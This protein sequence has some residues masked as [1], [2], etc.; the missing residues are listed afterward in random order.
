[1][2]Y[3]YIPAETKVEIVLRL[4]Q[5]ERPTSLE[6]EFHIPRKTLYTWKRQAEDALYQL[7]RFN[8][9]GPKKTTPYM[10]HNCE[11]LSQK[12]FTE[13]RECPQCA[14]AQLAKNGS[15]SLK[16]GVVKQRLLC[17]SCYFQIS[18]EKKTM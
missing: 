17:K 4:F 13:S 18:I 11:D 14:S 8:P 7:F 5:G 15:Y 6:K 12:L 16:S 1:M 9:P 10:L 3:R 2:A